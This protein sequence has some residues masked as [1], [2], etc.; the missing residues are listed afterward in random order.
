MGTKKEYKTRNCDVEGSPY[1]GENCVTI[2]I[3]SFYAGGYDY[4]VDI[5][6]RESCSHALECRNNNALKNKCR[7]LKASN[8]SP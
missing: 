3:L 5:R 8:R 7:V 4:P 1:K 6:T 2:E